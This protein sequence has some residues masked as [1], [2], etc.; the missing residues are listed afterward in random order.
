MP[1]AERTRGDRERA[2][3]ALGLAVRAGRATIGTRATV[4]AAKDGELRLVLVASDA[5][6]NALKRLRS[7][8]EACPAVGLADR[9]ELGRS[10]GRGPTAVVGV[11]DRG[12]A[13]KILGLAARDGAERPAGGARRSEPSA[14]SIQRT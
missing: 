7:A 9:D 13:S 12:L 3:G 4:E 2:L 11:T 5:T 14:R 8:L 1:E 10:V 6:R